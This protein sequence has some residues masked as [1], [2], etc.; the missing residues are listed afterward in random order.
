MLL[1][2]PE[3]ANRS[4]ADCKKYVY[5]SNGELLRRPAHVGEPV[6]RSPG[7]PT[8]CWS[9]PKI[10][11]DEP[12]KTSAGAIELTE[13]NRQAFWHYQQCKAVGSFP[14]DPIVRRNAAIIAS[15]LK[16]IDDLRLDRVYLLLGGK[17]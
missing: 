3:I 15:V 14:D 8:P 2:H 5:K 17:L 13:K 10:P 16:Q 6:L 4:C 11:A 7:S 1:R 12:E 9:C